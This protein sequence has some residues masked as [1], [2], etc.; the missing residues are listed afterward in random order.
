[1]FVLLMIEGDAVV[2][3]NKILIVENEKTTRECIEECLPEFTKVDSMESLRYV[4]FESFSDDYILRICDI[5]DLKVSTPK[6]YETIESFGVFRRGMKCISKLYQKNQGNLIIVTKMP[7]QFLSK[8]FELLDDDPD[9]SALFTNY[10]GKLMDD[11]TNE[12]VDFF[13]HEH[14]NVYIITKP[15]FDKVTGKIMWQERF[16][17]LVNK[18][19]AP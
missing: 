1:M 9:V 16:K 19:C 2:P 4:D 15:S 10:Y 13:L 7:I 11:L 14:N 12:D 17:L 5:M 3:S 8:Y 6:D 18:I